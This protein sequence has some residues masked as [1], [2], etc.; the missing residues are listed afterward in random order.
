M[1][2]S[3]KISVF[4]PEIIIKK[5]D[6]DWRGYSKSCGYLPPNCPTW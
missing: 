3:S 5:G 6:F 1:N 2:F 4:F